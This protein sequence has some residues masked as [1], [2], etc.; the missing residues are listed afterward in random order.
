MV[1]SEIFGFFSAKYFRD[2]KKFSKVF[3]RLDPTPRNDL[4]YMNLPMVGYWHGYLSGMRCRF[5]YGPA[6]ATATHSCFCKIQ[7][8][9]G[10]QVIP[11]KV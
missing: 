2:L 11:D 8:G 7:I 9:S 4:I 6:D 3:L 1:I 5:A 10:T